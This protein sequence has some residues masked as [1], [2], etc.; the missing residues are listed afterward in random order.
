V[1]F[2]RISDPGFRI[3]GIFFGEIFLKILVLLF[4][5]LLIKLAAETIRSKKKV[6]FIFHPSCYLRYDPGSGAF[7]PPG[8]GVKKFRDPA[9]GSGIKHPG[10]AR[11]DTVFAVFIETS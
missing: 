10:S 2:F 8:S 7:L 4:F 6:C 3:E 11:L 1:N 9:P 5:F